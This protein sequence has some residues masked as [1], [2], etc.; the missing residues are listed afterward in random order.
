MRA[1]AWYVFVCLFGVSVGR[2]EGRG[3][4]K[5]RRATSLFFSPVT[6]VRRF[7]CRDQ[8]YVYQSEEQGKR[9]KYCTLRLQKKKSLLTKKKKLYI[10]EQ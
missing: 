2:G 5:C 1:S 6:I 8:N 3:A 4:G 7:D 9:D 10:I